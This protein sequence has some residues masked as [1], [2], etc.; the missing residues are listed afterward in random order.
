MKYPFFYSIETFCQ[1]KWFDKWE[2]QLIN[3]KWY[4]ARYLGEP[5]L[6][7]RLKLAF[8]V[9]TGKADALY[10]PQH[11]TRCFNCGRLVSELE[12]SDYS[13]DN[14][15]VYFVCKCRKCRDRK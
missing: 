2:Q 7:N 4:P 3:G 6:R 13:N 14:E 15:P 9:F 10:W 12:A 11:S 8:D 5:T 1:D